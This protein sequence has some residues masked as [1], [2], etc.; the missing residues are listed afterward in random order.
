MRKPHER[1]RR[2][3]EIRRTYDPSRPC[4]CIDWDVTCVTCVVHWL[5]GEF[6]EERR[7]RANLEGVKEEP[8]E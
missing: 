6:L 7:Q 4:P 1:T 2:I 3:R 5:L 8:G